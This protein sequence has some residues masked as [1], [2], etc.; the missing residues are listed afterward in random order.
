[1]L[2]LVADK[3]SYSK[4][5]P[6]VVV[7]SVHI[8]RG[9]DSGIKRGFRNLFLHENHNLIDCVFS[10]NF[11]FFIVRK[12][13]KI[14]YCVM[15]KEFCRIL[16]VVA[17]F[18]WQKAG[19]MNATNTKLLHWKRAWVSSK[20]RVI[21]TISTPKSHFNIILS[22]SSLLSETFPRRFPVALIPL[23]NRWSAVH[24]VVR[25]INGK[26]RHVQ[27]VVM[28]CYKF[29]IN[30]VVLKSRYFLEHFAF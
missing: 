2:N 24:R 15:L 11:T 29:S 4:C 3:P 18:C 28:C 16:F 13:E 22:S 30:F 7:T 5:A 17:N 10:K 20:P 6:C 8:I 19:R 27:I 1:M 26:R 12:P 25:Y 14:N 9:L 21:L 23:P